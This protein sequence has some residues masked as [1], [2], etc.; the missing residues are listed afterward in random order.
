MKVSDVMTKDVV[1]VSPDTPVDEIAR[2]MID[3]DISG[4]P[5]IDKAHKVVGIITEGDLVVRN[6]NLHFPHFFQILDARIYVERPKHFEEELR[7]MLATVAKDV[8][9]SPARTISADE[10]LH[11]AATM[12]VEDHVNPLPVV[13][14]DKLVGIISRSDIIR[15]MAR[16]EPID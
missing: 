14:A 9:T 7:R 2:L 8:M 10:D 4:I 11:K 15:L 13:R 3:S 5:V 6:A 16:Q 12:M 1:S